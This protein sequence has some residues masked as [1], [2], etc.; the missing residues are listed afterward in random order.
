MHL[1]YI[2]NANYAIREKFPN[3]HFLINFPLYGN[4]YPPLQFNKL[5][6]KCKALQIS[7]K[8]PDLEF[9][10]QDTKHLPPLP[11]SLKENSLDHFITSGSLSLMTMGPFCFLSKLRRMFPLQRPVHS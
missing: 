1:E 10:F 2:Y 8:K 11:E 4:N 6:V 5:I 3:F 9:Y 7:L